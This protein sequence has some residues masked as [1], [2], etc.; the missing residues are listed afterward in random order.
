MNRD[1]YDAIHAKLLEDARQQPDYA[2]GAVPS[3]SA[4]SEGAEHALDT[5]RLWN[6]RPPARIIETA[7]DLDA[8]PFESVITDTYGTPYVCERHR[9]D[10]THNEWRMSGHDHHRFDSGEVLMHA[11]ITVRYEPTS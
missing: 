5:V 2:A 1:T 8:L 7:A 4:Y 10:G 3:I 6:M 9:T 11:P